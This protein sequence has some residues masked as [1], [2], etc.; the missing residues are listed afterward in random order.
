MNN[1]NLLII[2]H[3]FKI[4]QVIRSVFAIE[5]DTALYNAFVR[6]EPA[7]FMTAR[8]GDRQQTRNIPLSYGVKCILIF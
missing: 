6:C 4:R 7:T 2:S 3:R 5:R 8:S 1:S